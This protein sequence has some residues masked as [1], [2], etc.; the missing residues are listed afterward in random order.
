MKRIELIHSFL[1]GLK[2]WLRYHARLNKYWLTI[3]RRIKTVR[4]KERIKVLFVI[5][6]LSSW[7]SEILYLT[8]LNHPRFV[9]VLGV[10]TVSLDKNAKGQ[11]VNYLKQKN[12][13]YTDLD[14]EQ[15]SIDIINP[16]II[17]YYKPY[18]TCYS[19]GHFFNKNLGYVFCG[20]DYCFRVTKHRVHIEKELY[21]YCWQFY[22]EHADVLKERKRLLGYRA[23]NTVLSG[24]PIQDILLQPKEFFADP[25]KDRV[26]K[27]RIIYAPHHSIKGTN[28][29]GLEFSTFLDF[30]IPI[31]EM[32]KKYSEKITIAFKPHPNLYSK[33]VNLWG[34]DKTVS[35][36]KEW[37]NLPNTQLETGEYVGLF[38]YSDAIIHDSASFIVEYLY[39]NNPS[40]FLVAETNNTVDLFDFV[41]KGF[42]CYEHGRSVEDIERF[43]T[44]VIDGVDNNCKVRDSY[45]M[46]H[47]LPAN[48][49]SACENI[50]N[51]ILG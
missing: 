4:G 6:E 46:N 26:G 35:Y 34:L 36:Y 38:K 39:M 11:L 37:T 27:K 28:G 40:M 43:I 8:M 32:A 2:N 25:W 45:F 3:P 51:S 30:G 29:S 23:R 24:V 18:E 12:Y 31:L 20:F 41:K 21:D 47:L 7:K 10:S 15:H 16:D 44:N 14:S 48:G 42:D 19:D 13:Q 22:V 49:I 5:S 50:I 17:F 1:I 9:P 33:L